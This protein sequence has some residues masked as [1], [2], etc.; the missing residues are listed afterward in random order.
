MKVTVNGQTISLNKGDFVGS[1]GE[2]SIYAKNKLAYKVYTDVTR[3]IPVGKIRELGT[4]SHPSI[5]RPIDVIESRHSPVGY[6]MQFVPAA[7]ALCQIFTKAFRDRNKITPTMTASL[8]EKLKGIIDHAH[9]KRILIVDLNEMNFLVSKDYKDLFAIDVDSWQTPS[10]PATAIMDSI[11]DRHSSSFSENT[12]WFS[13]GIVSFQ[14][15]VGIHPYKGKHPKIKSWDARMQKN[16]SV[17]NKDVSVPKACFPLS[18]V[19]QVYADWYKAVFDDGKRLPPPASFQASV[20]IIPVIKTVVGNDMF[21]IQELDDY[22]KTITDVF[23]YKG[24]RAVLTADGNCH[25]KNK[26]VSVTNGTQI[27]ISDRGTIVGA[28]VSNKM[29]CLKDIGREKDIPCNIQAEAITQYGNRLYVKT[30]GNVY[31]LRLNEGTNIIPS[32]KP[33]GNVTT[34]SSHLFNGLIIQNLLGSYYASVFPTSG[35]GYQVRIKELDGYRIIDA[36]FS[37]GVLY[38][39]AEKK[40][41]YYIFKIKFD[42]T[43]STYSLNVEPDVQNIDINFVVL[44][45]GVC[46]SINHEEDLEMFHNKHTSTSGK[47]VQNKMIGNDMRLFTDG[48]RL[49]FAKGNKLYSMRMK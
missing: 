5:V 27:I 23:S 35:N 3:M 2:G 22:G 15:F 28:S 10:F 47:I 11:R 33:V 49:L 39:G 38:V 36:K 9:S 41:K 14:L 30:N 19:P 31:E 24:H 13:F 45:S 4:L 17:F 44:D 34:S 26:I 48:N 42:P 25:L 1:G 40:S 21:D 32:M 46:V 18:V 37:L 7:S 16:I 29:L 20:H 6:T 12:D 43:F 8:V